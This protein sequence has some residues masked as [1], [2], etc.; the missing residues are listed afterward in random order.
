MAQFGLRAFRR[1]LD[2]ETLVQLVDGV[3]VAYRESGHFQESL[4]PALAKMLCSPRFLFRTALPLEGQEH[5]PRGLID[6]YSLA[7]R[8]SY[9]LWSSM[10]DDELLELA[11]NGELRANLRLTVR[12]DAERR[13]HPAI[14]RKLFRPVVADAKLYESGRSSNRRYCVGKVCVRD[15]H[16]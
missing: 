12:T 11:R 14:H 4:K 1:P 3:E 10:P 7:S 6:E 13:A 8:L 9:F 5:I 2:E 16:C 15:R